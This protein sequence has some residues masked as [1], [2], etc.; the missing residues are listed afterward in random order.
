[1]RDDGGDIKSSA[2]VLVGLATPQ[3]VYTV[4]TPT[5]PVLLTNGL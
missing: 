4:K 5:L 2:G 3:Q 1:M